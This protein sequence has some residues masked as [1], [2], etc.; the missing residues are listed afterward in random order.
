MLEFIKGLFKSDPGKN[1]LEERD[2]L[3]KKA[4]QL[5]R[6]GDLRSYGK[7][8]ARIQELETEYAN[9]REENEG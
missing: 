2:Q 9:L 8:M 4:V 6:N 5:Q 1:I 3:Y 7:V